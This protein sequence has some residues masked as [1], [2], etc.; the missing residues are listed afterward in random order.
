MSDLTTAL[1]Q[2][3]EL[4]DELAA[5]GDTALA[6]KARVAVADVRSATAPQDLITPQE[7]AAIL[8]IRSHFMV[9]RWAREKLLEGFNVKGRVKVSRAS[10]ERLKGSPL[11]TRQRAREQD[12]AEILDEFDVGDEPVPESILPHIGR[13]PWDSVAAPKP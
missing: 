4:A 11:V 13:A 6:E 9:M 3:D 12:L 2:L 7:A 1:T 8:G 10:V 5:R